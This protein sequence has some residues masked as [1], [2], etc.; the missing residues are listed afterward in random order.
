MMFDSFY[1]LVL[2]SII[3]TVRMKFNVMRNEV[4]A[5]AR[6]MVCIMTQSPAKNGP[7]LIR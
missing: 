5:L 7:S 4:T 6:N 3:P 2:S 1:K